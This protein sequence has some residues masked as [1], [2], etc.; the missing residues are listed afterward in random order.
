MTKKMPAE[1]RPITVPTQVKNA[2]F[3]QPT[4]KLEMFAPPPEQTRPFGVYD[5]YVPQIDLNKWNRD[6][7]E[8]RK[9]MKNVYPYLFA[10]TSATSYGPNVKMPVQN[11]YNINLPGP[12]G[13]HVEMNKIYENILPGKENKL[14]ATTLGERLQTYDFVKQILIK[15]H[16]GEDISL[17]SDGHNSLMSYI[18]F[19]EL[20]PNYYNPIYSN[21]YKGLPFGLLVYRSCFPIR[22]DERSQSVV[23]AKD[24]IGL[25]IRLYSLSYAEYYSYKFR[26][27]I[28]K[29]YDVWR[30]VAY[31][32]YVR[33]NIIKKKQSPNFPLLYAFFL[34]PNR[35]IDFFSLKKQCLTQ[36]DMLTKEYH[37]F[38][39]IHKIFSS[40][41]PS[42]EIIRPL[43]LPDAARHVI[44][45]LPDEIDPKLQAYSGTTMILIT[46]APHHNMYQWASRLYEHDGIV[47]K[48][49]SH[50]YHDENVW[51]GIIFQIVSAL[52]VMQIHGIYMRCMTIE[53]NVYIKD[54]Q[55]FGKAKGYWK[56]IING[57]S[58]YVPN[59]GY[60]VLIDSNFKDIIPENKMLEKCKRE[61]KIYTSNICGKKYPMKN[62]RN[63]VFQ[64]YKKI[65]NTNAFSKEH[66]QNNVN[67]PPESIMRII[68]KM[69]EDPETDNIGNIIFK[70][71]R[72]LMNNRIGTF[73]RK[74]TE[75]PNIRDI[76]SPFKKGDMAIEIIEDEVYKWCSIAD[77]AKDGEIE[78]ITRD[79]VK[80]NDF[81]N[82]KVRVETLKQYSST[83]KI[84]QNIIKD[85]NLSEEELLETYIITDDLI[86]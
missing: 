29:E 36:K 63:N 7:P 73:L 45:K 72:P 3:S 22:L 4:F 49:I 21:P 66:T 34:S 56:Y 57:V 68:E 23:C 50:G 86:K 10:P 13:G 77:I 28:S 78:I 46:E 24:S 33:E 18:K 79:D 30:E 80:C 20:N 67:R 53:D 82:K 16:D 64:N 27:V 60:I 83:E 1:G 9:F 55:T 39:E 61:Y 37:R 71:F 32:E 62:I 26:Q 81:T 44:A 75:L 2:D 70:H 85:V 43:S 74:D 41:K 54:L 19:M 17:D 69:M 12:T 58:Y 35:K 5:Q 11:V 76:N 15:L 25:N 84:D 47:R 65:I 42:N 40:V 38:A 8:N 48:M 14:T 51:L 52:Y 31:Y 59:Y 6:F